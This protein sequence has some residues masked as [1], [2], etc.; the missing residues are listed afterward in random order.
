MCSRNIIRQMYTVAIGK[1]E[2]YHLRLQLTV[3]EG[4]QSFEDLRIY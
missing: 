3:V 1:G 4:H 2:Q